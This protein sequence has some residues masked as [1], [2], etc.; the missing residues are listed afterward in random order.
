VLEITPPFFEVGPKT[1]SYGQDLL[2][3]AVRADYLSAEY[4][5]QIVLTPQ[6]VDIPLVARAVDRVLVFAQHMDFLEPGRGIGAV[7]P[8]ALKAAGAV[9]VL[10]NHAEKPL[11]FDDLVRTMKRADEVGLATM[12]CANDPAQA[13]AIASLSPDIIIVEAPELIASKV[14]GQDHR[15]N[16]SDTD[17][18]IWEL[19]PDIRVL[20]AAGIVGP[21]DVYD[22]IAA[23]AQASGSSSAIFAAEDPEAVLEAMIKAAR[24]AW[25]A[26]TQGALKS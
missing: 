7:L 26:R 25:D 14:A 11:G 10:L 16:I 18:A 19:D 23:G 17:R 5:V 22:V 1:Y 12:V 24:Q 9:G 13:V 21:S 20:H 3:L 8:E 2:R 6:Y 15:A 4:G